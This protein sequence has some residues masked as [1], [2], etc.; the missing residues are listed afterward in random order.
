ML[1]WSLQSISDFLTVRDWFLTSAPNSQECNDELHFHVAAEKSFC[2]CMQDSI[3]WALTVKK[4]FFMLSRCPLENTHLASCVL[5][6]LMDHVETFHLRWKL[7]NTF[8]ERIQNNQ[9]FM[10]ESITDL[11]L[12]HQKNASTT[13]DICMLSYFPWTFTLQSNF[14]NATDFFSF[15][16]PQWYF[17]DEFRNHYTYQVSLSIR[18]TQW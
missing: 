13:C 9:E 15:W 17:D 5:I 11:K 10:L 12:S 18:W 4:E 8:C 14:S 3:S 16:T 1:R 6:H 2:Y 7:G